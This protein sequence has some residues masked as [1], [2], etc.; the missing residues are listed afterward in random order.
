[1]SLVRALIDCLYNI[2]SILQNPK[3]KGP[4]YRKSGLK[5]ILDDLEE[6]H[7]TYLGQ[8]NWE[9][10]Y[11]ERREVVERQIRA[12]GYTL[13]DV[14]KQRSWETLGSYISKKQPGGTLSDHQTFIKTFTHL[15]WR[16]YSALS[17]G[18]YEAFAGTLG[19]LPVG[20]YYINDF[21]PHDKRPQVDASYDLLLSTHIG[22]AATVLLC[23]VTEVQAYCSFDGANIN[24]RIYAVWQALM[25]VFEAKELYDER[26]SKLM[27]DRGMRRANDK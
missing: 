25:P 4:A 12:S 20:A 26:Y 23:L 17:H 13:D 3:E 27:L 21:M 7:Q 11:K 24:D 19:H 8:A 6:D 2:T 1:M 15:Q 18:A 22:R 5:R 10:W 9:A 14:L 16:Q